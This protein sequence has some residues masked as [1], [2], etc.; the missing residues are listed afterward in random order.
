MSPRSGALAPRALAL[1]LLGLT[2]WPAAAGHAQTVPDVRPEVA[3][4]RARLA[5]LGAQQQH[6][7]AGT[8]QPVWTT[9]LATDLRVLQDRANQAA[10]AGST[11]EARRWKELARKAELLQA[12][13]MESGR[14]G[15][16][17]FRSQEI[18]LDCLDRHAEEREALRTSLEVAVAEPALYAESLRLA[19]E[20][21]ATALRRDLAALLEQSRAV[22]LRWKQ[23]RW[24]SRSEAAALR[25]HLTAF[26]RRH[27]AA[28]ESAAVRREA[29]GTLR[30]A[31]ALIAAASAWE[32]ERAAGT[33]MIGA[34][35]E[36]ERR[37]ATRERDEAGRLAREHCATAERW[38]GGT[39][40]WQ[41]PTPG[42]ALPAADGTP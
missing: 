5:D 7:L 33:R 23:D 2:L 39:T 15:A 28:F 16:D 34:R 27:T 40:A 3:R 26:R 1:S 10:A 42:T 20:D 8:A 30:A 11:A 29:D 14:T 22:F 38:I 17:L 9:S 18:G 19:G 31:E 36:A 35:H 12:Q 32:Q 24:G 4:L 21:G 25:A 13:V 37:V 41:A 6:C